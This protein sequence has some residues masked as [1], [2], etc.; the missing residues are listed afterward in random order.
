MV[1]GKG[2]LI[3]PNRQ[4]YAKYLFET[5]QYQKVLRTQA[6]TAFKTNLKTQQGESSVCKCLYPLLS[7]ETGSR[8]RLGD[9]NGLETI[10]R[11]KCHTI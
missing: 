9:Q 10:L 3:E 11:P 7:D 8:D 4:L 2:L 5:F 6:M 1:H